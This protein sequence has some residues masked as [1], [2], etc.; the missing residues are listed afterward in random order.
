[1]KD[2]NNEIRIPRLWCSA[3]L[4]L[5]ILT[6]L[7]C[8]CFYSL[9]VNVSFSVVCMVNYTA[10]SAIDAAA[11]ADGDAAVVVVAWNR[12][13]SDDS[14]SGNVTE[15]RYLA[16]INGN[17]SGSDR[18][19]LASGQ[20]GSDGA[21][22]SAES[23]EDGELVWNKEQQGLVLGSIFW[24]YM[25]TN[26]A[27]GIAATRYG[28]KRVI[29]GALAIASVLTALTPVAA[30][31]SVYA[32]IGV[33]VLVGVCLGCISPALHALWAQWAPPQESSKLRSFC[34]AGCQMGYVMTFPV[35]ALLCQYGFDGGWPTVFYVMAAGVL[36][37]C[38]S[39]MLLV[40]DSPLDHPRIS[41]EERDYIVNSLKGTISLKKKRGHSTPWLKVLGSRPV[42]AAF[43]A[44]TCFN[45]GEYTFLTNIPTY[46]RE[47]LLFDIK[48][49]GFLSA[50]PYI[51][52]WF[53]INVSGHVADVIRRKRLLDT[54]KT[55]KLFNFL[56]SVVP[57]GL[58]IGVAFLDCSHSAVAVALLTMGVAMTGCLYGAGLY[59]NFADLSPRHAGVLYGISNTIATIPGF[60]APIVIGII[61][62]DQTQESWRWVFFLASLIYVIGCVFFFVLGSGD[63]QPWAVETE[64]LEV[65]PDDEK[66]S[67]LTNG[68]AELDGGKDWR[69]YSEISN[70]L[71][72]K[73]EGQDLISEEDKHQQLS[74][75][76]RGDN[77]VK[78]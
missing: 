76:V 41:E 78:T 39:W 72:K 58:L 8:V 48:A 61:T 18:N 71:E 24:G 19:D 73:L 26:V 37:W 31:S 50:L 44:H 54:T 33:R 12:N 16:G 23:Y 57:A 5:A 10:I 63:I 4:N 38:V 21:A 43:I 34:F 29:G 55:R 67:P 70:S 7:G 64:E 59:I 30:R 27:G 51:C 52:F 74:Q 40:T 20:C 56:G 13:S 66:F 75:G 22:S 77:F 15:N 14:I 2:A 1:M 32:V 6:M 36:A 28:G 46:L 53:V 65:S 35:T 9:R 45:W 25:L 68:K 42:W 11:N 49:N 17:V 62:H 47:V 60:V 3:R 69:A